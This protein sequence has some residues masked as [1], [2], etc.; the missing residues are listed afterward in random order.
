MVLSVSEM[1]HKVIIVLLHLI[2]RHCV[3]RKKAS[4]TNATVYAQNPFP[5][6]QAKPNTS[7]VVQISDLEDE[8]GDAVLVEFT[9][10]YYKHGD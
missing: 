10:Q 6:P 9:S 5:E 8:E 2:Y 7:Q 1:F 4:N 3:R